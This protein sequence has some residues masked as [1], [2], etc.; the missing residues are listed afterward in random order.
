MHME[1][2][3][4][5]S[6]AISSFHIHPAF[7]SSWAIQVVLPFAEEVNSKGL[8]LPAVFLRSRWNC[9]AAAPR[10]KEPSTS[11][12]SRGSA[13]ISGLCSALQNPSPALTLF[14]PSPRGQSFLSL[15]DLLH[16]AAPANWIWLVG[17]A[18]NTEGVGCG[19]RS[20]K[21]VYLKCE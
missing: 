6:T 16:R 5:P 20:V 12:H 4:L 8:C 11:R 15:S 13:S 21:D 3:P 17:S 10:W 19:G 18:G 7:I 9:S 1:A 2:S 14:R